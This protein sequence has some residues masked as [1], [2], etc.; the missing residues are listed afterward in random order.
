[1]RIHLINPSDTSFGIGVITPR[2]L[3]VLAAAT[4][5]QYGD[6]VVTDETLE[7][8]RPELIERGDIVGIGIHTGNA[9][10]GM[11]VGRIA[12]ERG[13][14]VIYG[15][16]HATLYTEEARELGGAHVEDKGDGDIA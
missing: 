2:W 14:W 4:P 10:R 6:P 12:R 3:Y 11:E 15:G 8:I 9:L 5:A 7:Q 1:M 13:A 16:I